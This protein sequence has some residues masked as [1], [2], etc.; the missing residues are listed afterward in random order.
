MKHVL[1][2]LLAIMLSMTLSAQAPQTIAGTSQVTTV[3]Q[4]V[5]VPVYV[6]DFT[7]VTA[8]S[9]SLSYD[10]KAL[11]FVRMDCTDPAMLVNDMGGNTRMSGSYLTPISHSEGVLFTLVY[12]YFGGKDTPLTWDNAGQACEWAGATWTEKG[13]YQNGSVVAT[14]TIG[15]QKWMQYNVN[16]GVK[17]ATQTGNGIAEKFCYAGKDANCDVYG[18]LYQWAEAMQYQSGVT[19]ATHW[20]T[21]PDVVQGICPDGFR[22]PT[23]EDWVTLVN[24]LGGDLQAG[25]KIKETG[26]VHWQGPY[27]AMGMKQ[28]VGATNASGFTSLPSGWRNYVNGAYDKLMQ[29]GEYWTATKGQ[30]ASAAYW[31]GANYNGAQVIRGEADKQLAIAVRCIANTSAIDTTPIPVNYGSLPA[32]FAPKMTAT[33]ATFSVPITVKNF[34]AVTSA[35]LYFDFNPNLLTVTSVAMNVTH[36]SLS[37]TLN[38]ANA[39]VKFTCTSPMSLTDGTTLFTVTFTKKAAGVSVFAW[40]PECRWNGQVA[41]EQNYINGTIKTE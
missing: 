33:T 38:P 21:Q 36:G 3:G 5:Y 35:D 15:G 8:I 24:Y 22:I 37:Y 13:A 2:M 14:V 19:N 1:S 32:L 29:Y 17:S 12:K 31:W 28:N 27:G 23:N 41:G 18:G 9:L 10:S 7:G 39:N 20:Q 4:M 25:G 40:E 11:Q 6:T 16:T 26:T 30:R 34:S